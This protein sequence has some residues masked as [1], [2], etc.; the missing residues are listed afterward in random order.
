MRP[1]ARR[2]ECDTAAVVAGEVSGL[3]HDIPPARDIVLRIAAEADALMAGQYDRSNRHMPAVPLRYP[4]LPPLSG[5]DP[6]KEIDGAQ[7]QWHPCNTTEDC[8]ILLTRLWHR[9]FWPV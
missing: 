4:P 1:P 2:G 7:H 9:G 8:R 5:A 6:R 3:V